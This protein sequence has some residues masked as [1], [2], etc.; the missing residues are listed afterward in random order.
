MDVTDAQIKK[1]IL[2]LAI[3]QGLLD[4]GR[5]VHEAVIGRLY[6]SYKCYLPDCGDH[7]EYLNKI[8]KDLY[9]NCYKTIIDSIT[10]HLTEFSNRK[11]IEDF[12]KIISE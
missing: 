3:E 8:L 7:P 12:I 5:P 4:M 1:A 6:K 2:S 11:Q 9:G 10:K